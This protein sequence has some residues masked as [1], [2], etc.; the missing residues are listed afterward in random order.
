MPPEPAAA[1][2]DDER[3]RARLAAALFGYVTVAQLLAMIIKQIPDIISTWGQLAIIA[4]TGFF[5][6]AFKRGRRLR[7]A[8]IAFALAWGFLATRAAIVNLEG[9]AKWAVELHLKVKMPDW[10][11]PVV[12]A[13]SICFAAATIVLVIGRPSRGR[14]IAGAAL[15]VAFAALFIAENV[16]EIFG[17][18]VG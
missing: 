1:P 13:R 12:T 11:V 4:P 16:H 8:S 3:K 2:A 15:G 17:V 14:R 5:A 10:Y 7:V 6:F 18:S 9:A